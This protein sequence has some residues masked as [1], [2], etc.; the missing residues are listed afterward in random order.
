MAVLLGSY[1]IRRILRAFGLSQKHVDS[2][3]HYCFLA[4]DKSAS[5][6]RHEILEPFQA[7]SK[8]I[9]EET[10]GKAAGTA[11]VLGTFKTP[12]DKPDRN[13]IRRIP[14]LLRNPIQGILPADSHGQT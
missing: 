10:A 5:E 11:G 13:R 1:I 3:I 2:N 8:N 4:V 9:S 6:L 14:Y 12:Q 7:F